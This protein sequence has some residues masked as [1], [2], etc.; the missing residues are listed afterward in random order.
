MAARRRRGARLAAHRG[1]HGRPAGRGRGAAPHRRRLPAHRAQP[2]GR[3]RV[4]RRGRPGRWC[5]CSWTPSARR[6][7]RSRPG[8]ATCCCA[9]GTRSASGQLRD[10][11]AGRL[12]VERS[13]LPPGVAYDDA[14]AAL[15]PP[16]LAGVPGPG[17]RLGRGAPALRLG[18][19]A[20][21][22]HPVAP[23]RLSAEW[24]DPAWAAGDGAR[25]RSRPRLAA[26]LERS[27]AGK[28]PAS[29]EVELLLRARGAEVE[30]VAAA[31]DELRR[32]ATGRHGHLRGEPQH[33][34]HQ[35]LHLPLRLLRLL[36]RRGEP[37]PAGRRPS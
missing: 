6:W 21:P 5:R 24:A 15:D 37:Q 31:A 27:L 18:A 9:T 34:L 1:R 16:L 2:G 8:R 35:P 12:L 13:A 20:R 19:R 28:R 25:Q 17:G 10:A 29:A 32:R 4:S 11:L 26:V 14:A 33:Q 3:G 23:R 36:P 30:A 7:R 22:A